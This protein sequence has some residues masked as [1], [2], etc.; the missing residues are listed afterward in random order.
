MK[1]TVSILLA[2]ALF[3][4]GLVGSGRGEAEGEGSIVLMPA[5]DGQQTV[6]E[7]G[8][9]MVTRMFVL[10]NLKTDVLK[11]YDINN[12]SIEG[13]VP[14]PV[15]KQISLPPRNVNQGGLIQ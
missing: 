12:D 15:N 7:Q 4:D 11:E 6:M 14:Q 10:A 8:G 2:E 3:L 13:L 5:A 1:K 9:A